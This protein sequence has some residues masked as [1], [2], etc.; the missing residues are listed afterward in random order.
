L[1]NDLGK[2]AKSG[3]VYVDKLFEIE[4]HQTLFQMTS[5]ISAELEPDTT[6]Y[7]IFQGIFPC[8][9]ITGAPKISTMKVIDEIEPFNR[10]IY[11]G[12]IGFLSPEESIFSVPIR[13]LQKRNTDKNFMYNV[14]G[15]IV[16]NS[17]A[18]DEWNETFTKMKFLNSDFYLIETFNSFPQK[19]IQRMKNSARI[20]NFSW[21]EEIENYNYV[22]GET[23]R[24]TLNKDGKC[25]IK[26]HKINP[27]PL[28]GGKYKIKIEGQV[29]SKNPFL[30]HKTS[31]RANSPQYI[32]DTVCQNEKGEITEGTFTN[33][34]VQ[35][36]GKLFTPPVSCGLLNG[37]LRQDLIE[38][39]E[40][41]EKVL[42]EKDLQNADKIY[43]VNS[44]R[45]IVEVELC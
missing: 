13:I 35:K 44:I 29:N 40:V 2:F 15:A 9:S 39:K 21:N 11:C 25:T 28:M 5:E 7:D 42:Y 31:I 22:K 24:I 45:G 43:C 4:K 34:L 6:L 19:H 1:R 12:A 37:I 41:I 16:W 8:G 23:Y 18:Q 36:N 10:G 20:L 38:K 33:I 30:Y 26:I 3:S 27:R 32:F 14:G 17:T